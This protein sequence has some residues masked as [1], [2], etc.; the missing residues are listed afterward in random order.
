M[1]IFY[2]WFPVPYITQM[3]LTS[4]CIVTGTH[5]GTKR[6]GQFTESVPLMTTVNRVTSLSQQL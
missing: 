2:E 3:I 4:Q 6:A 5:K 1:R